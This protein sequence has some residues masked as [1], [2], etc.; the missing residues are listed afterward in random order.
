MKTSAARCLFTLPVLAA[1]CALGCASTVQGGASAPDDAAVSA[2]VARD[3][4]S[5]DVA[6][7]L[8][9]PVPCA[10]VEAAC[11]EAPQRL[12]RATATGLDG[13]DGARVQVAVRY[14]ERDDAGLDAPRGLALGGATVRGGGFEACACVPRNAN[15][16]PQV[17][18]VVLA[19]GARGETARDVARGFVSQRFAIVGPEDVSFMLRDAPSTAAAEAALA[20]LDP[21]SAETSVTGV[22]A[23]HEGVQAFAGLVAAER[24][25]A[26]QVATALVT[27]AALRF[28]W[29][30]PGRAWP[31]ERMVLVLDLDGDRRCGAGDVGASVTRDAAGAVVVGAASWLRGDALAPVCDALRIDV[32]RE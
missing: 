27:D 7:N 21:R 11:A 5:A 18:V 4:V 2:D 29:S 20:A 9:P 30:M 32:P 1:L 10:E 26:A 28:V 12:F 22:D 16:Y 8:P 13:L 19:P 6:M 3:V 31:T 17:A 23:R 14:L 24:P 25:V 15:V